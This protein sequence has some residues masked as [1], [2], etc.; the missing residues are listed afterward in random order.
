MRLCA[1][2]Y[3]RLSLLDSW[4]E[5]DDDEVG[6][7]R[8]EKDDDDDDDDV[9]GL[10]GGGGGRRRPEELGGRGNLMGQMEY[11]Y[12]LMAGEDRNYGGTRGKQ[13]EE[14]R[15]FSREPSLNITF[16][17]YPYGSQTVGIGRSRSNHPSTRGQGRSTN[18][19]KSTWKKSGL[20]SDDHRSRALKN[21]VYSK[22]DS[23]VKLSE[24]P[25]MKTFRQRYAE[26][27]RIEGHK[28]LAKEAELRAKNQQEAINTT[29]QHYD[30]KERE[31]KARLERLREEG[32]AREAELLGMDDY[33][34][35]Q[36]GG[37]SSS[38]RFRNGQDRMDG[39]NT[40]RRGGGGAHQSSWRARNGQFEGGRG[41]GGGGTRGDGQISGLGMSTAADF[42]M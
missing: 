25:N 39:D 32:R 7:G 1:R 11:I 29:R 2:S 20:D 12:R 40:R 24:N 8:D 6:L 34:E 23:T 28:I 30:R 3:H 35:N 14:D 19:S 38:Y 15:D 4:R 42:L 17:P 27:K 31:L 36:A 18:L 13:V 21:N 9:E 10:G 26:K 33:D 16:V 22:F 5:D 37:E 41:G